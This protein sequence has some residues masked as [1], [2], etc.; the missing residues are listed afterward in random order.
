MESPNVQSN[1]YVQGF[2]SSGIWAK[3]LCLCCRLHKEWEA[4][5]V[6]DCELTLS[7]LSFVHASVHQ[8]LLSA[9]KPMHNLMWP[10]LQ[11]RGWFQEWESSKR[12]LG[13]SFI[14]F[15]FLF[16]FSDLGSKVTQHPFGHTFSKHHKGPMFEG[17][18][19]RFHFKE[20]QNS[21]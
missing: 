9:E 4:L 19:S 20:W 21:R 12:T 11:Q 5:E 1:H 8:Y 14:I 10:G 3:L 17:S 2:C 18:W 6:G 15:L 13:R 16:L 7:E